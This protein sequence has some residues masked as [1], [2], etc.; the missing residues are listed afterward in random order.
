MVSLIVVCGPPGSGKSTLSGKISLDCGA[1]GISSDVMGL[2][3]ISGVRD[4]SLL[5]EVQALQAGRSVMFEV[6]RRALPINVPC[7][8]DATIPSFST[9]E[10]LRCLCDEASATL[11]VVQLD[12][13][14]DDLC[15]R[16]SRRQSP[17]VKKFDRLE[18]LREADRARNTYVEVQSRGLANSFARINTSHLSEDETYTLASASLRDAG[19]FL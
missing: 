2:A 12:A 7:L 19:A 5:S 4:G 16:A 18:L 6:W 3:V 13:S 1:L 8:H 11:D 15:L 17:Q 10:E 14:D 9:W